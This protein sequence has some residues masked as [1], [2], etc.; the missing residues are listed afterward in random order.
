MDKAKIILFFLKQHPYRMVGLIVLALLSATFE[1]SSLLVLFALLNSIAG[2]TSTQMIGQGAINKVDFWIHLVPTSDYV[3]AASILVIILVTLKSIFGYAHELLSA[4]TAFVIWSN[5]QKSVYQKFLSA[6]YAFFLNHKQG[7]LIYRAYT[8]AGSTGSVFKWVPQIIFEGSKML[9]YAVSL[10]QI[11]PVITYVFAGFGGGYYYLI[12]NIGK[13]KSYKFSKKRV[14]AEQKEIVLVNE[15]I[16]GIRQIKIS[17][18]QHKWKDSYFAV[19]KEFFELSKK[20][21]I[22]ELLPKYLLDSI[23]IM[24]VAF[25][26]IIMKISYP[27][28]IMAILPVVGTFSYA[29]LRIM[30]SMSSLGILR[31]TIMETMPTLEVLYKTLNEKTDNISDG[32]KRLTE[33]KNGIY[34][35]NVS[36][37]YQNGVDVLKGVDFFFE[38]GKVTALVG[39]SGSGKTTVANLMVRLFVPGSGAIFVDETNLEDCQL[40]YWLKRV[41]FVTQ[42]TFIFNGTVADNIN[43]GFSEKND[44]GKIEEVSRIANAHS[45][46]I[47]LPNGYATIVGDK[48]MRLSG[49]QRQR[50]A[51]ARALY[52]SP[53][54]LILDEATSSLD[55]FSEKLIQDA[56]NRLSKDYTIII[57]AHRLSTVVNTNKIIVLDK[58]YVVEEGNHQNLMG[59][60]GFYWNLYNTQEHFAKE[61]SSTNGKS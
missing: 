61:R 59:K 34:F 42:D 2:T 32:R 40:S 16:D 45:F 55:N 46:I 58:G 48:G 52:R 22:W 35:K 44:T 12:K 25:F 51:I 38:R 8:A 26:L 28:K 14:A 6:D 19:L 29:F 4:L 10:W 60:K 50:I 41:G 53:A 20:A 30:P 36:F 54:V 18:A 27:D 11:S 7:D 37:S 21:R 9:M 3:V 56:I 5:A 24:F 1:S 23:V 15:M 39:A 47:D 33:F 13:Y 17:Q 57:I 43:F 31:I 49:G